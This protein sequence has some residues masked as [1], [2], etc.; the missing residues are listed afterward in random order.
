MDMSQAL[1]RPGPSFD[2][3]SEESE[4]APIPIDVADR[5]NGTKP[6]VVSAAL[7]GTSADSPTR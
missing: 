5:T 6:L 1:C 3:L 4:S 7:A 2:R